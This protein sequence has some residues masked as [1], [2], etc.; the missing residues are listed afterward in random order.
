MLH[1]SDK[2]SGLPCHRGDKC[3]PCSTPGDIKQNCTASGVYITWCLDCE[4]SQ[5][6]ELQRKKEE[7]EKDQGNKQ[8]TVAKG[9]KEEGEEVIKYLYCGQTSGGIW[10][11]G[12][13]HDQDLKR[14]VPDTHQF[15]HVQAHHQGQ[16]PPPKFGM[17]LIKRCSTVLQRL[18]YEAVKIRQFSNKKNIVL[19]NSK[20]EMSS[21]LPVLSVLKEERLFPASN[22]EEKNQEQN[23]INP[24]V[25]QSN[26]NSIK[27]KSKVKL[28]EKDD[29]LHIKAA[30][31]PKQ[32]QTKLS[33]Y[34]GN[35]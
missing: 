12:I 28:K 7:P 13:L 6:Q 34:F 18:I 20:F 17:K 14:C 3:K 19:L 2:W 31:T 5:E 24:E 33:S 8:K 23:E 29:G 16:E 27:T 35:I 32:K 9:D 11:R 22:Q 26:S 15:E 25:V 4:R 21:V 10:R 30:A 1:K